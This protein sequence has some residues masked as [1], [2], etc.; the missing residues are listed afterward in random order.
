MA[1]GPTGSFGIEPG[2]YALI[3]RNLSRARRSLFALS[4]LLP[5]PRI[6]GAC[7]QLE[8]AFGI[9]EAATPLPL[10][11]WWGFSPILICS[12][13]CGGLLGPSA[14]NGLQSPVWAHAILKNGETWSSNA[15][16]IGQTCFLRIP[17]SEE[18]TSM[19]TSPIQVP[20]ML[21]ELASGQ[22][23]P[24][25]KRAYFHS[26]VLNSFYQFILQK[27]LEEERAG[28][29]TKAELARRIERR[30]EVVTRLL[31]AP[32]NWGLETATDLL[33]GICAEELKP[34]SSP[35][36]GR[37]TRNYD[38]WNWLHQTQPNGTNAITNLK[39]VRDQSAIKFQKETNASAARSQITVEY[40]PV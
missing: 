25:E 40:A 21:S 15:K 5:R 10:Y 39:M 38:H 31:G 17:Q 24:L 36:L 8:I 16:R 30:P 14:P 12:S 20:S 33:L 2:A 9:F 7:R 28:R 6:W 11:E 1:L 22:P 37:A 18:K 26:R 4:P 23:I 19:H 35:L 32:G 13:P 34:A 3:L 27:F 29:L